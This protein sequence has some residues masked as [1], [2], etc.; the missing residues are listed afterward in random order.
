M[1]GEQFCQVLAIV[2][3]SLLTTWA[4][5]VA[6]MF[7]LMV[8]MGVKG[9]HYLWGVAAFLLLATFFFALAITG[10]AEPL[11]PR[12]Q[13]AIPIRL[14]ALGILITGYGWIVLWAKT[15]IVIERKQRRGGSIHAS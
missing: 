7:L 3:Y 8:R 6:G 4:L 14:V 12:R 15:H 10:G 1:F 11:I 13:L 5:V 2:P 9:R